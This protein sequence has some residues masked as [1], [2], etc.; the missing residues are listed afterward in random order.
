MVNFRILEEGDRDAWFEVLH[1]GYQTLKGYPI[2]FEAMDAGREEA[3]GWFAENPTY[4][5]FKDGKLVSSVT[6]RMPWG[7]KPGPKN[8]P[9]I[10]WFVTHKEAQGKGYAKLLFRNLEDEVLKRQLRLPAVTLGTAKE[11]P[12][13]VDF[14]RS[15]GFEELET[16]QLAGK[17][18]HTVFLEKKIDYGENKETEE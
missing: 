16:V 6:L 17:K 2:S 8:L 14:Y 15:I 1:S 10:G 7:K 4:G 3:Y 9:H 5:L 13:L 12:W 18:H 11:H